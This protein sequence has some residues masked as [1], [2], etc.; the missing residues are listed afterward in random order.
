MFSKKTLVKFIN[1]MK[2]PI[3]CQLISE[4][5]DA[6]VGGCLKNSSIFPGD[7]R[8]EV[9]RET[10]H[11]FQ[12]LVHIQPGSF[13]TDHWLYTYNKWKVTLGEECCS[14]KSISFHDISPSLMYQMEYFIYKLHT[15]GTN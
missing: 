8:D 9:G 5:E 7:T 10:F 4:T 12:P 15:F 13:S 6:A 3:K 2:T 1:V 11:P 14:K